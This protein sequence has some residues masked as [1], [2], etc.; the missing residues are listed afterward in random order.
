MAIFNHMGVSVG[1]LDEAIVWYCA[2]FD[3][4]MIG[5]G[6]AS[7]QTVGADRRR[8]IFGEAWSEMRLA[9]LIDAD[10][11]GIELFQFVDPPASR[12]HTSFAYWEFGVF[13]MAF[14]VEDLSETL[15]RIELH[16]GHARSEV[17][18]VTERTALCYCEDPW[19]TVI[20]LITVDYR[21]LAGDVIP[22]A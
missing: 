5:T 10:G 12:P 15:R 14:T 3:L 7:T 1:D 20:E 18:Q 21:T 13:H 6:T 11:N 19:G 22:R 17:H 8:N 2:V 16:G 9:H 4:S